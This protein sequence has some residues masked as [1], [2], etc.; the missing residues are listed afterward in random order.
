M[1]DFSTVPL[2]SIH[3]VDKILNKRFVVDEM[4]VVYKEPE[5]SC[6]FV[7]HIVLRYSCCDNARCVDFTEEK[8]NFD[9]SN[10]CD[11]GI[12]LEYVEGTE[13]PFK[14]DPL[15]GSKCFVERIGG[16]IEPIKCMD[17][18]HFCGVSPEEDD[19]IFAEF[20]VYGYKVAGKFST[21]GLP[22]C[23]DVSE[24]RLI[25]SGDVNDK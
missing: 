6:D 2:E 11:D 18:R 5:S 4:E 12:Y 21:E 23:N 17:I 16:T 3:I 20:T 7:N 1:T 13:I 19:I 10:I 8:F 24:Y 9:G 14:E 22:L 25:Y 15:W